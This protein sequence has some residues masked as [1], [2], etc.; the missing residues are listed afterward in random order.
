MGEQYDKLMKV[1]GPIFDLCSTIQL[2]EWDQQTYMP[3]GGAKSRATQIA[4]LSRMVH[5]R[6]TSEQFAAAL[7]AAEQEVS[8]MDPD[9]EQALVVGRLR[10]DLSKSSRIPADWV[11]ESQTAFRLAFNAWVDARRESNFNSFKSY[12]QKTL[13]LKQSYVTFFEPYD[14]PY[15]PLLDD[16][17]P[18]MKAADVKQIFERL[19]EVQVPLVQAITEHADAVDDA[20]LHQ[21]YDGRKQWDFGLDVIRDLGYD[22]ERG[23]QDKAPHPFSISFNRDDVRITNRINPNFFGPTLF[24]SMHESG[25]AMYGQGIAPAYDRIPSLSGSTLD[26]SHDASLG[27][28]ESQSRMIENLVGRSRAFWTAY[29]PKLQSVFPSQ[30]GGVNSEQFYKAINR[31]KPTLNRVEADEATYNLHIMLRFDIEVGLIE[32]SVEV[33]DLP[34]IWNAKMQ[35]YFGLTPP[36][37]A[38]GVLQDIHWADGYIGYFPTYTLGNIIASQLW[39]K[40]EA[41][42]PNLDQQIA[43]AHFSELLAWLREHVHRHAGGYQPMVLLQ[44]I[45][46]EGLNAQPYLDYLTG[47]YEEIYG[48][49]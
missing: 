15:D 5:E 18:G 22:F 39:R 11:E 40:V 27:I 3:P 45:T 9:S 48:L 8:S 21:P 36:N 29:Y 41:D 24:G 30:L 14:S 42:I 47:K 4:T 44:R 49:S 13:E 32:G 37:D 33:A 12:L 6:F 26:S 35:E 17:E 25:H 20:F 46:G 28:H 23:R 16:Y 31:V 10:R 43:S 2:M 1:V 19:R 38:E 34:E 7:E